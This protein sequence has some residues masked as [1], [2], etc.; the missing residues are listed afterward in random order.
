MIGSGFEEDFSCTI[1]VDWLIDLFIFIFSSGGTNWLANTF[2][3]LSPSIMRQCVVCVLGLPKHQFS[4]FMEAGADGWTDQQI[5]T[6]K[7]VATVGLIKGA[8]SKKMK[9][10]LA[11][12]QTIAGKLQT[13]A[14]MDGTLAKQRIEAKGKIDQLTAEQI[15]AEVVFS[16]LGAEVKAAR[17]YWSNTDFVGKDAA[18]KLDNPGCTD[19]AGHAWKGGTCS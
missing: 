9:L 3:L 10:M 19:F 6:I 7:D 18:C 11:W 15:T 17:E 4:K 14:K 16:Q 5:C 12:S 8:S 13:T 2:Q 1:D